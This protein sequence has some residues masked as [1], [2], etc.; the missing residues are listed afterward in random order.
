MDL[1]TNLTEETNEKK[2]K[3]RKP[4]LNNFQQQTNGFN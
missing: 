1:K 4:K 2:K 3:G